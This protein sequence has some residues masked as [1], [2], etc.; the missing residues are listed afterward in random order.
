MQLK[1]HEFE[2]IYYYYSEIYNSVENIKICSAYLFCTPL[3]RHPL[4]QTVILSLQLKYPL[5]LFSRNVFCATTTLT[6]PLFPSAHC[7]R[8]HTPVCIFI[9]T[10]AT[11]DTRRQTTFSFFYII[12]IL[13]SGMIIKVCNKKLA[14]VIFKNYSI[15]LQIRSQ[16]LKLC[17]TSSKA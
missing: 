13:I 2:L 16:P 1:Y 10:P 5:H 4:S 12:F 7:V 8:A 3:H 17:G 15:Q 14:T 9:E 11:C 6:H